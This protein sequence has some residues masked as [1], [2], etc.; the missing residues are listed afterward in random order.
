MEEE[1]I[2]HLY[3]YFAHIQHMWDQVHAYVTDRLYLRVNTTSCHFLVFIIQIITHFLFKTTYYFY[4][5]YIYR[6]A[7]KKYSCLSFNNCL[8]DLIKIRKK[9]TLAKNNWNKSKR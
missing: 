5:N 7:I 4:S 8:N 9:S 2:M 1:S 6:I 3:Y